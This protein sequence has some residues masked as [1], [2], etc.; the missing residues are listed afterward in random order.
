MVWLAFAPSPTPSFPLT[1][2]GMS[3]LLFMWTRERAEGSC[4][5][6]RIQGPAPVA[7]ALLPRHSLRCGAIASAQV[8]G[9][10]HRASRDSDTW[11]MIEMPRGKK[12]CSN[13]TFMMGK[14]NPYPAPF[15]LRKGKEN[16]MLTLL[17]FAFFFIRP[18]V[19]NN[20][21]RAHSLAIIAFSRSFLS[22]TLGSLTM[23]PLT[24]WASVR[25]PL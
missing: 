8:P 25:G 16:G 7:T 13:S 22:A 2:A 18:R 21:L 4:R 19:P 24:M 17:G 12:E 23:T 1:G 6:T 9:R 20:L 10:T 14:A 3:I 11:H 15:P 5:R